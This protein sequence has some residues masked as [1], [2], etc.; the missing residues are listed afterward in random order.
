M[1]SSNRDQF[2]SLVF[3]LSNLYF[4]A[5]AY[6]RN[7]DSD[8]EQCTRNRIWGVPFVLAI[9][10]FV[11]RLVQSIKRWFDSGLGTHLI[12][13]GYLVFGHSTR[14]IVSEIGREIWSWYRLLLILFY[15]ET[16]RYVYSLQLTSPTAHGDS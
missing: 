12:N 7:F 10:P 15:M 5:C 16:P 4:V 3:T 14:L 11:V 13:V 9:L 6:T 8:W 2:C 1:I